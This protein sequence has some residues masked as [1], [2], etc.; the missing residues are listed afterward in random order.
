VCSLRLRALY[1]N[2][3][4][5]YCKVRYDWYSCAFACAALVYKIFISITI[6]FNIDG[7]SLGDVHGRSY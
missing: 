1:K 6:V 4:C 5:A 3:H 2:N 7:T